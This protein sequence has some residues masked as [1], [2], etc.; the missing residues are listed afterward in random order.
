MSGKNYYEVLQ[1]PRT[2]ADEDI[3]KAYRRLALKWHP[4]KNPKKQGEATKKFKEVSEAYEVL[5]DENRRRR[6]DIVGH[7]SLTNG[8]GPSNQDDFS[9]DF[10]SFFSGFDFRTPNDVFRDF[11]GE[12][13][14]DPFVRL[15]R[16]SANVNSMCDRLDNL[17]DKYA[18]S[19]LSKPSQSTSS[20]LA[21][22]PASSNLPL[23]KGKG[24]AVESSFYQSSKTTQIVNGKKT[25]KEKLIENGK[26][27][28]TVYENGVLKS[29]TVRDVRNK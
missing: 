12:E 14:E 17:I 18:S 10:S 9:S 20:S 22:K 7:D 21:R 23:K 27:T 26:E 29:K 15:D 8:N 3:K 16:M 19:Q 1:V 4:D 24:K 13:E 11:F 25:V 5:S 6:Y 28:I 2:A